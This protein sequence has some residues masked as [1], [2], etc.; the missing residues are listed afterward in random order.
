[1]EEYI[2][3]NKIGLTKLDNGRHY[4]YHSHVYDLLHAVDATKIGVPAE[5]ITE[6]K[7][8]FDVEGE[9]NRE[10]QASLQTQHMQKKD[11]ERDRLLSFLFGSVRA[12]RYSPEPAEAAA[13]DELEIV[14]RPYFGIQ[15]IAF[16][17][18]S[19]AIA[20]LLID[21]RKAKN[22]PHLTTLRLT[23]VLPKLEALN[24]EF[25]QLYAE[26]SSERAD[27]KELPAAKVARA[28]T[29]AIFDRIT[30]ILQASYYSGA[31]PLERPLIASIVKKMNQRMEEAYEKYRYSLLQKR[32]ADKKKP[33]QP[34]DP[35]DPKPKDPK[36]PKKPEGGGDDIHVPEEPPKKPEDKDK[37]KQPETGGGTGGGGDDIHVPSEP[38][39]KPDGQ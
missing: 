11:E 22:T 12:Y 30:F 34:K 14:I 4:E 27:D 38:P 15:R 3:I 20:G 7:A 18:E 1:M 17:L 13:A 28:K 33:K 21:L 36:D 39:K 35:K 37:P 19:A 8:S 10:A 29:D 2:E 9:I 25:R 5:K 23:A 26:R 32:A 6:Y 16:D 24:T 31:A